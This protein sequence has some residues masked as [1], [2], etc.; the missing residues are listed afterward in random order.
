[1]LLHYNLMG[2]MRPVLKDVQQL[3]SSGTCG[4]ALN[5]LERIARIQVSASKDLDICMHHILNS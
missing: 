5:R 2:V 3:S 4:S 1:M